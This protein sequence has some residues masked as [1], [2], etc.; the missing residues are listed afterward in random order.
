MNQTNSSGPQPPQWQYVTLTG[1]APRPILLVSMHNTPGDV[2]ID[3]L[4]L[5]AGS[6][7]EAGVNLLT[8]GDFEIPALRPM[9][10]FG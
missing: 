6:V 1:T 4:K 5:V 3:D 10:G 9:D 8:N 2:Y 7:P